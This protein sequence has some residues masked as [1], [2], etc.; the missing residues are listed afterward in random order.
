MGTPGRTGRTLPLFTGLIS[1]KEDA[2]SLPQTDKVSALVFDEISSSELT[3]FSES[4]FP[5]QATGWH[6]LL[7]SF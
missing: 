6:H 4:I 1:P 2:F 3:S 7:I 5:V